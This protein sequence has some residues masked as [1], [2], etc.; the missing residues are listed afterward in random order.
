VYIWILMRIY[1]GYECSSLILG[2]IIIIFNFQNQQ[3]GILD[4]EVLYLP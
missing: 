2:P 4:L 3:I 1:M